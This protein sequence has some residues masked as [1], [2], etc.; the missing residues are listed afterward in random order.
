M[1]SQY[2]SVHLPVGYQVAVE[3]DGSYV[4]LGVTKDNGSLE[5]SYDATKVQGSQAET[6]INYVKNMMLTATF[7]LY[8]LNLK[9]INMLMGGATSYS[10]E[11][12][13]VV[14]GYPEAIPVGWEREVFIP[15]EKQ[16]GAGTVPANI[17]VTNPSSALTLDTDYIVVESGGKW[18]IIVL[19]GAGTL[20]DVLNFE[21]DYTPNAKRILTAG[22]S[23]VEITPRSVRIRKEI[24]TGKYWTMFLYSAVNTNGLSF[25]LPRFDED[26]PASMEVVMEGQLDKDRVAL[27]Q[28]FKIEDEVFIED[29]D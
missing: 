6:V 11:A 26:E 13:T 27:D 25:P 3:I 2:K 4:D 14:E 9:N 15:F 19:D 7:S 24:E 8:Q 17:V 12:G 10:V 1:A 23:T 22:A 29:I 28:L 18:G 20:T 5:F 21:Y 16:N